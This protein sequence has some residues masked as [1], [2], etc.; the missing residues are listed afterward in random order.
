MTHSTLTLSKWCRTAIRLAGLLF[1]LCLS[2]AVLAQSSEAG[3]KDEQY[4]LSESTYNALTEINK[5]LEAGNYKEALNQLR[6][7]EQDVSDTYEKAVV[8]QTFGY[9]Y[10]G[11]QRYRQAADAFINAVNSNALP[12]DVSH[13]LDYFI[14]QLLAQTEDYQRAIDFL[15]Q[16]FA[17]ETDPG[18]DAYRL[19][20]G[21]HYE[22]E[23][24][25]RVIDYARKAINKS[26]QAREN[27]YQLLLAAYFE[28][29]QYSEAAGLLENMLQLFPNE[30]RY[31][32]QLYSTYQLLNQENNALAV[33]EL[34]YQRGY[35]N[36][37]EKEQLAR[38]Y[39][40]QEAPYRA[41][42]F[43][44]KELDSGGIKTTAENLKLLAESFYIARETD[45]AIEAYARAAELSGDPE[46]YFRRGQLLI[47]EQR[48]ESAQ[49]ALQKALAAG[50]F[51]H[52]T[53][54]QLFLGI[55]A[56]KLNNDDIARQ[57]LN[58]ASQDKDMREQADYWLQQLKQR[59]S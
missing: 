42:T 53:R 56:Y 59:N 58:Q 36:A 2:P 55:A 13:K 20:A 45:R 40:S 5:L 23:N 26:Q 37:D 1:C 17:E 43:L 50:Q 31:W 9:A 54:A 27:L 47:N 57:A 12:D 6:P 3:N 22:V 46:L 29:R 21:I 41:A 10:N 35:L 49:E 28:T 7:L 25:D 48:W 30:A 24:Y 19:A 18:L 44:E 38:L 51:E 34:A 15:E 14:A 4:L 16:W 11:L 32:K 8:Q 33:Y 52:R 39:L